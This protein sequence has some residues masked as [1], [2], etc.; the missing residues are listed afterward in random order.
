[1]EKKKKL[2]EIFVEQNILCPKVVERVVSIAT[3]LNKRFGTVLEE[4]GLITGEELAQALAVQFNCRPV[5]KFANSS[6]PPQLLNI[7]TAEVA[8][9]NLLFPLK[10][11]NNKLALALADPTDMRIIENIAA[12]NNVSI[13]PFVG[14]QKEIRSAISRHYYK[15]EVIDPSRKTILVVEDDNMLLTLLCN[16]LAKEY[17]VY[18]ATDGMEAYKEVISKKPHVILTD[19][20]MP[21]LDGFGLIAALRA[22]PDTKQIPMILISGTTSAA[23]EAQAFEKGFFDFIPK[24]VKEVTLLTRVKRAMEFSEKQQ[25]LFMR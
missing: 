6:F 14:T 15:K 2:G 20:E 24:P 10:L 13:V 12:N 8:I 21:K 11:E 18:S 7:V 1:V 3:K 5:F 25:Y 22:V 17:Q 9:Q 16:T 19:K 23:A 4:M